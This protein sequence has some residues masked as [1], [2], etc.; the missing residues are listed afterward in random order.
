M[1]NARRLIGLPL[2]LKTGIDSGGEL[3][4]H[5]W[6]EE[7]G[8][9]DKHIRRALTALRQVHGFHQY[10]PTGTKLGLNGHQGVIVD[11]NTK[12]E[13]IKETTENQKTIYLNPQYKAFSNWLHSGYQKYPELRQ[14][15]K[16]MLSTEIA[17]LTIMDEELDHGN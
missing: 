6:A 7:F 16:A 12:K 14:Y 15:F 11:I 3:T 4:V 5:E 2:K 1:S 10:H 8:V 9:K 17:T 13:Y